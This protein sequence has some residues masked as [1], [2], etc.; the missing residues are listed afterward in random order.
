MD[1]AYKY[2]PLCKQFSIIAIEIESSDKTNLKKKYLYFLHAYKK[3]D[4]R[5]ISILKDF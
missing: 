2:E 5:E 3:I 1:K 4:V